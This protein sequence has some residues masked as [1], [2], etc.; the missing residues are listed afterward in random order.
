M[1]RPAHIHVLSAAWL[2]VLLLSACDKPAPSSTPE[3][4]PRITADTISFPANDPQLK[5]L[6]VSIVQ[7]P[8]ERELLLPGRL[9]WDEDRTVR[10]YTPYAGRVGRILVQAGQKVSAGQ[11]LAEIMSPDFGQAQA[12]ARKARADLA[13][14]AASVQR[15]RELASAGIAA[16]KDLQQ[17]E[18]DHQAAEAE[19]N[20]AAARLAA[21]GAGDAVDQRFSLR[22]PIAG[23]VVERS[24]NPG[25]ELRPDQP[26]TPLFVVTDPTRLWVQLD[27]NEA[28]LSNLKPGTLLVISSNQYPEETF[29]GKLQQVADFI[30]P[31]TRTLKLRG[32]VANGE[33]RLKAEMFISARVALPKDNL[34]TVNEKAVFLDG[35]RRYVFVKTG[36][37]TFTRR[38]VRLGNSY[39]NLVPAIAGLKEGDEVVVGGGLY[40][41]QLLVSA[42]TRA[43]AGALAPPASTQGK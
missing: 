3:S 20:R 34:P 28:D 31:T 14:K 2:A 23:I 43:D 38:G 8:R 15:M 25:Q 16:V 30:D 42:Q 40:L 22:S 11:A 29:A 33:M 41:Q 12:D 10:I 37:G 1:M 9:V 32:T 13:T 27:A 36:P 7:P 26:G 39:A 6:Q 5:S 21:S 18:A 17:A 4:G 24:I 35:V 19:F